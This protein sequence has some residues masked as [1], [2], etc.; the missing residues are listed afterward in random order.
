MKT[1]L[2]LNIVFYDSNKIWC[3][4]NVD[5]IALNTQ[6]TVHWVIEYLFISMCTCKRVGYAWVYAMLCYDLVQMAT[7]KMFTK[8]VFNQTSVSLLVIGFLFRV[9]S[10]HGFF[11]DNEKETIKTRSTMKL[12]KCVCAFWCGNCNLYILTY[13]IMT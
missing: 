5:C 11:E 10:H 12:K 7:R 13:Q 6:F 8:T 3:V 2:V 9:E 4:T 1:N